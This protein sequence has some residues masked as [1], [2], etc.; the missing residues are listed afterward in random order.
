MQYGASF[1]VRATSPS[2]FPRYEVPD[3]II[4]TITIYPIAIGSRGAH[5]W[6]HS[7]GGNAGDG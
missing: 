3:I 6:R 2:G 4:A 5:P 7:S 1:L